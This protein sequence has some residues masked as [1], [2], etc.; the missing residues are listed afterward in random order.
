MVAAT[1]GHADVAKLLIGRGADVNAKTNSGETAL[2]LT[3][4]YI[5]YEMIEVRKELS[6]AGATE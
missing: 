2:S 4:P 1:H 3:R 6:S 5:G